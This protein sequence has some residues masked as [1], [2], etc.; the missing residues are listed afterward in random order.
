MQPTIS[1]KAMKFKRS[2]SPVKQIMIFADPSY[3][4]KFGIDPKELI[5]FAGGWVNHNAPSELRDSYLEIV[6]QKDLFHVS[7]G[8]A[9]TLGTASCK[10]AISDFEHH[11]YGMDEVKQS[12]IAI[13]LGSTQL[14]TDLFEVL[15]DPGDN[16]MLMDPSYCNYPTQILSSNVDFGILRFPVLDKDSWEFD[17]DQKVDSV[18]EYIFKKKPKVVL[19]ISPDNP[20]SRILSDRFVGA[21]MDAVKEI[22]SYLVIDFAYK[23]I[24]FDMKYPEYYSWAPN[25]NYVA[26]RSNSKWGRGLGR[27]LG[28][29]EGPEN[30]IESLETIMGSTILSPDML[31]QMAFTSYVKKAIA[32]NT[33]LPY[34]EKV[35]TLYKSAASH[36][37]Q[38]IEENMAVPYTDPQG[39]LYTFIKVGSDG[40]RFVDDVLKKT[41]VLLVPGWG[42]GRTGR[43]AIRICYGPLVNDF[44]KITLGIKKLANYIKKQ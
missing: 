43:D 21:I 38:C 10:T 7:G 11:I 40:A 12:Q 18:K 33:L 16:I 24:V 39:G 3:V 41:G 9:P 29:I 8:Y 19:L 30:V 26:L 34:L 6:E 31:H 36:T 44:D 32:N 27:R 15:L 17:E 4:K 5:S 25:D 2:I 22:G 28:W 20:T 23:E 35:N 1:K 37:I 14:V 13:G 42:F